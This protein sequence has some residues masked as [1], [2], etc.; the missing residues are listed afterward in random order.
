MV[1]VRVIVVTTF[2]DEV[3]EMEL[4]GDVDKSVLSGVEAVYD[5]HK[6]ASAYKIM[7]GVTETEAD[8]C[9][10]IRPCKIS[11]V[12]RGRG[13]TCADDDPEGRADT[14]STE[15]ATCWEPEGVAEATL[16]NLISSLRIR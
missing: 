2:P 14:G 1:D 3:D 9:C 6:Y 5:S 8:I 7:L 11:K 10:T 16:I 13:L 12:G 15:V 4:S